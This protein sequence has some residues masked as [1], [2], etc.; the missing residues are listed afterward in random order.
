MPWEIDIVSQQSALKVNT[1]LLQTAVAAVLQQEQLVSAIVSISIVDNE[2]IHRINRQYLQ[3][4]YPT[5]VISFQLGFDQA[6]L[7]SDDQDDPFD[8]VA[9]AE[10]PADASE[11]LPAAGAAIEGEIIASAEMA[12]QMAPVGNWSA[13]AELA[14]YV[15][16]GL[17]HLC[18]YD[19][20]TPADRSLMKSREILAMTALGLHPVYSEDLPDT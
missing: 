19:D 8:D 12:A 7:P 1:D 3:H 6:E 20:L 2:T 15:V 11:Q 14:L 16:H 17:L 5:D 4:D 10:P 18:G 9:E 13:D